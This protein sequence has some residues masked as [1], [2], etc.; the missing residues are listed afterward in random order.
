MFT[1]GEA[2]LK[3]CTG[4]TRREI[5]QVG[6]LGVLGLTLPGWLRARAVNPL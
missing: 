2:A 4:I 5:L 6:G 3:N 1:I